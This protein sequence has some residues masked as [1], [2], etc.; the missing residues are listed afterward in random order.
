[1]NLARNDVFFVFITKI[2][3]SGMQEVNGCSTRYEFGSQ[4]YLDYFGN[5]ADTMTLS[6]PKQTAW[7]QFSFHWY[8]I[9]INALLEH[10]DKMIVYNLFYFFALFFFSKIH[11]FTSVKKH[12]TIG[13]IVMIRNHMNIRCI[14]LIRSK[15]ETGGFVV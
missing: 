8:W 13:V 11:S 10:I 1:M 12:D 14:S 4:D 15:S 6:K 3:I 9:K 2:K 7:F 5:G